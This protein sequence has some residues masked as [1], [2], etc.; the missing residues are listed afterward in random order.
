MTI[1]TN[2][3]T[4]INFGF[5][6]LKIYNESDKSRN[7]YHFLPRISMIE[8]IALRRQ[9]SYPTVNTSSTF[10]SYQLFLQ[11]QTVGRVISPERLCPP[12]K[13]DEGLS[14]KSLSIPLPIPLNR[15]RNRGRQIFDSRRCNSFYPRVHVP[16]VGCIGVYHYIIEQ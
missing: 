14:L 16:Y 1:R 7:S 6:I 13:D 8:I 12:H 11:F 5:Q 4:L 15:T 3:I 9:S 2:K 10:I